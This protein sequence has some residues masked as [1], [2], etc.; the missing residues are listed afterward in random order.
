MS[1]GYE[2]I[3]IGQ[4][5]NVS[6]PESGKGDVKNFIL[7]SEGLKIIKESF[8][9]NNGRRIW[10]IYGEKLG[11][12]FMNILYTDPN[13]NQL[14]ISNIVKVEILDKGQIL[15][16]VLYVMQNRITGY[17]MNGKFYNINGIETETLMGTTYPTRVIKDGNKTIYNFWLDDGEIVY[18]AHSCIYSSRNSFRKKCQVDFSQLSKLGVI[19][20]PATA[21]SMN[22]NQLKI[23]VQKDKIIAYE[24]KGKYQQISGNVVGVPEIQE[25]KIP[26]IQE[27]VTLQFYK[28][29]NEHVYL[30]ILPCCD[31]HNCVYKFDGSKVGCPSGG[32]DGKGDGMDFSESVLMGSFQLRN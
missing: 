13:S 1:L 16:F 20:L 8:D 15:D 18:E 22:N 26:E 11:I 29:K 6:V 7:V 17:V 24:Y 30:M 3:E 2:L 5:F 10:E 14:P 31:R 28:W 19:N 27:P 25:V 12:F 21:I 23:H 32:I 4:K 9:S